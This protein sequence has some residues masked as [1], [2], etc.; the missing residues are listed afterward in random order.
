MKD[1]FEILKLV[2]KIDPLGKTPNNINL[3]PMQ[4]AFELIRVLKK[5]GDPAVKQFTASINGKSDDRSEV[6]LFDPST[7]MCRVHKRK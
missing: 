2:G 1:N 4:T 6:S 3:L 5:E 7:N